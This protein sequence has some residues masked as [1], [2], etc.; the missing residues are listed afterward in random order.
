MKSLQKHKTVLLKSASKSENS[1]K[2]Y[3]NRTSLMKLTLTEI[4]SF[5][6]LQVLLLKSFYLVHFD[7]IKQLYINLNVFKVFD[8][9]VMT[10]HIKQF[11]I[12]VYSSKSSIQFIMFLSR[13]LKSAET[14][15]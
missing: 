4:V 14:C 10:Y 5:K 13:L 3:I 11:H 7:S 6:T 1:H 9:S 8:F 15:Y 2:F 12:E